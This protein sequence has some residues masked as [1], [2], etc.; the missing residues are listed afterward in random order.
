MP[1]IEIASIQAL[2][3]NINQDDFGL[4]VWEEHKLESHKGLFYEFLLENDGTILHLGNQ[5]MIGDMEGG[6]FAGQLINWDYEPTDIII[7]HL[8]DELHGANQQFQF[9]FLPEFKGQISQLL[10]IALKNSPISK[11]YFLTDYQFGPK[12]ANYERTF[13]ISDLWEQHDSNGLTWNTLYELY[14]K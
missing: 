6:F 11:I 3:L 13:L 5:E 4:A 7:P 1:T 9:Q 14:G 10:N 2:K 12:K 8:N